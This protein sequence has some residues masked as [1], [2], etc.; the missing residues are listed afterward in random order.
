MRVNIRQFSGTCRYQKITILN[1]TVSCRASD[2]QVLGPNCNLSI[3]AAGGALAIAT[4]F[5]NQCRTTCA[6]CQC[7]AYLRFILME[8]IRKGS[9]IFD[10]SEIVICVFNNLGVHVL[11]NVSRQITTYL[12]IFLPCFHVQ[13]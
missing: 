13:S 4:S 7:V 11:L 8:N 12:P 5:S 6:C 1:W 2:M 9:Q 3:S 10:A